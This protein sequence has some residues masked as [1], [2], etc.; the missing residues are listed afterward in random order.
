MSFVS[1]DPESN[2]VYFVITM[3]HDIV[4]AEFKD[5]EWYLIPKGGRPK[6]G[7]PVHW[8]PW[9]KKIKTSDKEEK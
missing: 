5:G 2:G 1:E 4:I 9:I 3:H 7:Y 6:D 8:V